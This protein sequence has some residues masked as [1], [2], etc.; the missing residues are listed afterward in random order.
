MGLIKSLALL[1]GIP[2]RPTTSRERARKYQRQANAL[3]AQQNRL[4][5][6]QTEMAERQIREAQE[7]AKRVNDLQ[8][9]SANA[10]RVRRLSTGE[11]VS[12]DVAADAA[13]SNRTGRGGTRALGPKETGSDAAEALLQQLSELAR[14]R[15]E[16]VLSEDEFALAKAKILGA[17]D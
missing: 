14:L 8:E 12:K 1:S 4:L 5:A 6:E 11:I 15:D 3:L 2:V 17:N 16:G 10:R 13:S 7:A 9:E